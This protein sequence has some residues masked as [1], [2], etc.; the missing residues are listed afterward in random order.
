MPNITFFLKKPKDNGES[1]VS[2][3]M[4]YNN[5]RFIYSTG[6]H[7]ELKFWNAKK[8]RAKENRAFPQYPE[9]NDFLDHL[10][11]ATLNFYRQSVTNGQLPKPN[12]IR[13]H[14]NRTVTFRAKVEDEIPL[15]DETLKPITLFEFIEQYRNERI[16]LA[17]GTTKTYL[18]TF[19]HL[20]NY[21]TERGINL[22]FQDITIEWFYDFQNY[23]YA[24]PREHGVNYASKVIQITK[25]FL[26]DATERGHNTNLAFERKA[27]SI[28]KE[29]VFDIAL[30]KSEIKTLY[31]L[32]LSH[33]PTG[34]R[35]VRDLFIIGCLTGLRFSDWAKVRQDQIYT[36]KSSDFIKVTTE[37]TKEVVSIPIAPN[38][39]NILNHYGGKL[40]KPLTNQKTNTYIKDIAEL[41][42]F[43]NTVAF[44]TSKAGKR[45]NVELPKFKMIGTHTARR[46][47]ATNAFLDGLEP[48]LIMAITG[49][50]TEKEFLKYIKISIAERAVLMANHAAFK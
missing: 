40:P 45:V 43:T 34:H 29:P 7:I 37:K 23:L 2:L 50:R 19:N 33:L 24:P 1:L 9:F 31:D 16:N 41:A 47:F 14:L 4:A 46:S 3:S 17:F 15:I 28:K 38:V 35:T 6:Q 26:S 42:G 21:A 12:D 30:S 48:F 20:K 32:D 8:Q 27:F 49:H 25:Q 18:S 5:L 10:E 13:E 44:V 36:Q 22:D 11:T 39:Q